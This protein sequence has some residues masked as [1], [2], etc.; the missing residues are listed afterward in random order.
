MRQRHFALGSDH[1]DRA[2]AGGGL[3]QC[4]PDLAQKGDNGGFAFGAGDG[5]DVSGWAPK[6]AAAKRARPRTG[7]FVSDE[8]D[9]Q[10][11]GLRRHSGCASTAMAPRSTASCNEARAVG[12]ACPPAP[13]TDSP[14]SPCGCRWLGL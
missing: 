13:R 12:P 8:A 5:G 4:R 3:A 10:R 11:L 7:I 9:A 1:A 2:Q 6:K 14:A